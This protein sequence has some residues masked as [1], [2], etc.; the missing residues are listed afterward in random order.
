MKPWLSLARGVDRWNDRLGSATAWLVVLMILA[1][2]WNALARWTGRGAGVA[3]SSNSLIEFQ[4]YLFSLVFLL[5]GA[6]TLRHNAHV[7]VDALYS[8]LAPR[9]KAL[10]N[11]AGTLLFLVPFCLFAIASS[12][13]SV[14]SSISIR[15]MSPDPGGLPR[16]PIK[17][18]VPLAFLL[19]LLQGLADAVRQWAALAGLPGGESPSEPEPHGEGL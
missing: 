4:W 1:G 2:A 17:A 18:A 8:R 13:P 3:L 7:R 9:R 16:W 5:G 11:L 14:A 12:W 10:V 6:H 19:L 15:E